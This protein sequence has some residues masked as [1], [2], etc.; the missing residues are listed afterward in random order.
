M[1]TAVGQDRTSANILRCRNQAA[2]C[3]QIHMPRIHFLSAC[4]A[5]FFTLSTTAEGASFEVDG[6]TIVVPLPAGFCELGGN[7]VDEAMLSHSRKIM[8]STNRVLTM[9]AD[10]GELVEVRNGR[11]EQLG[12]YGQVLTA[13]PNGTVL[14]IKAPRQEFIAKMVQGANGGAFRKSMQEAEAS[15]KS[16]HPNAGIQENLGILDSDD[17]AAYIGVVLNGPAAGAATRRLLGVTGMTVVKQ[18]AI[19]VNLYRLASGT[20]VTGQLAEQKRNMSAVVRANGS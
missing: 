9:F 10:C 7:P 3:Q 2:L 5:V 16:R 20:S 11:R 4:L 15:V 12:A 17:S 19:S 1:K 18:T 13:A 14:S 8:A 6:K